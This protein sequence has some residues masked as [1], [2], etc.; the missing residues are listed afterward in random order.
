MDTHPCGGVLR[1][2]MLEMP[3]SDDVESHV[4]MWAGQLYDEWLILDIVHMHE[5]DSTFRESL[6]GK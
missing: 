4:D 6:A 2:N 3:D 5:I 1:K